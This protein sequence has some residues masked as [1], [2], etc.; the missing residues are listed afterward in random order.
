M[1][2]QHCENYDVKRETFH[3]YPRN[4]DCCCTSFVNKVVI[5][6][7]IG[8]THLPC[9]I[10]NRLMTGPWRNSEFCSPRIS[11]LPET[12]SREALRLK[13]KQKQIWK[14][15]DEINEWGCIGENPQPSE[16]RPEMSLW[17][18]W[19]ETPRG[20]GGKANSE[21]SNFAQLMSCNFTIIGS[22]L[23]LQYLKEVAGLEDAQLIFNL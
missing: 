16:T 3:Y 19:D 18:H 1:S 20:N 14:P 2:R 13:T 5:L 10:A 15:Q 12:K 11:M 22:R 9:Y 23:Y 21:I 6:F 7:S 4:V 17:M 8:L